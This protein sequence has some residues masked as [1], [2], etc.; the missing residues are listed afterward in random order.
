MT[1][2]TGRYDLRYKQYV[3]SV[4]RRLQLHWMKEWEI[5]WNLKDLKNFRFLKCIFIFTCY[6]RVY[7]L[8]VK[9]LWIQQI[10]IFLGFFSMK[11]QEKK[12]IYLTWYLFVFFSCTHAAIKSRKVSDG[13]CPTSSLPGSIP[14]LYCALLHSDNLK[15]LITFLALSFLIIYSF[16]FELKFY[17]KDIFCRTTITSLCPQTTSPYL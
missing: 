7:H 8:L 14:A 5:S 12:K 10:F 11:K 17:E 2:L 1:N 6:R 15:T 3:S 13:A 9:I 4:Q 16:H